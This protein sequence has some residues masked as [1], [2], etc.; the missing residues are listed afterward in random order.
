VLQTLA[1]NTCSYA[2][3]RPSGDTC[4]RNGPATACCT[5]IAFSSAPF[6][7]MRYSGPPFGLPRPATMMPSF[8]CDGDTYGLSGVP[9]VVTWYCPEPS[10]SDSQTSW[11]L[12]NTRLSAWAA[13]GAARQA[14]SSAAIVAVRVIFRLLWTWLRFMAATIAA[15]RPPHIVRTPR[16]TPQTFPATRRVAG[17]PR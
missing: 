13:A 7:L 10:G 2:T 15:P 12:T 3:V 9:S 11:S 1:E 5:G 8:D 14:A 17:R 16:S 4:G 6:C